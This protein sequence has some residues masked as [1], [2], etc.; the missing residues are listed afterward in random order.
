MSRRTWPTPIKS[1]LFK[2]RK[3][4]NVVKSTFSA[5]DSTLCDESAPIASSV[6][7]SV[8]PS[9]GEQDPKSSFPPTLTPSARYIT[10]SEPKEVL[11]NS[12]I[13]SRERLSAAYGKT[14][15]SVRLRFEF[16]D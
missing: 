5:I 4:K 13:A 9:V 11:R 14:F 8:D 3:E 15:T 12:I 10:A 2:S 1:E 6:S 7:C 16:H